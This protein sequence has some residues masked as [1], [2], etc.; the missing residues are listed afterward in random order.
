M[1]RYFFNVK[2]GKDYQDLQG[3]ELADLDCA[4]REALR[5]T[6][7]LL[8]DEENQFWDGAA[9]S[10]VVT[11]DKKAVLFTLGFTAVSNPVS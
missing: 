3:T 9:W 4:R 2:D 11:D 7:A 6:S 8:G 1:P 10:M 5:F